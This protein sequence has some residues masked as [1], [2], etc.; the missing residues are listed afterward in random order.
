MLMIVRKKRLS[1]DTLHQTSGLTIAQNAESSV[2][3]G[4]PREAVAR[5]NVNR[6]LTLDQMVSVLE[7]LV[8]TKKCL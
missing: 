5:N 1:M 6:V 2:V 7:H 3:F 8:R 4:M